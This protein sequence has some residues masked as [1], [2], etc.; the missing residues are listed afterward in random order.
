[1]VARRM[2]VHMGGVACHTAFFNTRAQKLRQTM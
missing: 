1:L 2:F